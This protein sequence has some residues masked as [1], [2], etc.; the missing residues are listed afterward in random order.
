MSKKG[1]K[2]DASWLRNRYVQLL[3]AFIA[4]IAFGALI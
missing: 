4:G 1:V 3:L 2:Y